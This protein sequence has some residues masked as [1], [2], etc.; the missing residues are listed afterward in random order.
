M[1][2]YYTVYELDVAVW[3]VHNGYIATGCIGNGKD[4]SCTFNEF[5]NFIAFGEAANSPSYYDMASGYALAPGDIMVIVGTLRDKFSTVPAAFE[6][7]V[8]GRRSPIGVW[9]D[10][11][12]AIE[13]GA[14]EGAAKDIDIT[15][16]LKN[17]HLV[18]GA[19]SEVRASILNSA[20]RK[21]LVE[22]VKSA[23]WQTVEK[24]SQYVGKPWQ[25]IEWE[26]TVEKYPEMKD[27]NSQLFKDVTEALDD[28]YQD[29]ANAKGLTIK[30]KIERTIAGC[31][32]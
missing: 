21:Q 32:K 27:P 30:Q 31:F 16:H 7:L 8:R 11:G 18:A 29:K 4:N 17:A 2:Y 13:K 26:K 10:M 19:I 25:E 20:V 12:F 22:R 28:F 15:R 3:G 24:E 9:N 14:I 6:R 1:L 5:V 23:V